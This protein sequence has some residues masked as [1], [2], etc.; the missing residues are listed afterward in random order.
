VNIR[1]GNLFLP[2]RI[3]SALSRSVDAD[4]DVLVVTIWLLLLIRATVL[5]Y[6]NALFA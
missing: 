1:D 5:K 4:L 2:P 6:G 3:Q